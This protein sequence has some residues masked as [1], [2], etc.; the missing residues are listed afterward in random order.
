MTNFVHKHMTE[1]ICHIIIFL[2]GDIFEMWADAACITMHLY[3]LCSIGKTHGQI[4]AS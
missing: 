2:Q 1:F 4:I 3:L